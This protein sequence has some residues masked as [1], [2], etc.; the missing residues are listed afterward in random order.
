MQLTL[1]M[2][3]FITAQGFAKV[4]ML[5][6]LID[7]VV[8]QRWIRCLSL[9]STW[10]CKAPRWLPCCPRDCPAC[11]CCLFIWQKTFIRIRRCN[12]RLHAK[13]ILPCLAL[14]SALF[15]MQAS[16]SVISVCFNTSLLKYGGD[17]AVAL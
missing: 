2:N 5:S 12:L 16:E 4:G 7:A 11:G 15:V 8:I 9:A 3:A 14:G 1:G 6:V 10:V 13:V 17:L